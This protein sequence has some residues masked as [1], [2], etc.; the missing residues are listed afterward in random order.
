MEMYTD[1]QIKNL[2][3][4]YSIYL[5]AYKNSYE[6]SIKLLQL[7]NQSEIANKSIQELKDI[8]LE[9]QLEHRYGDYTIDAMISN[10]LITYTAKKNGTA[11][12]GLKG[13]ILQN[14]SDIPIL[15]KYSYGI[16]SNEINTTYN[17]LQGKNKCICESICCDI[18]SSLI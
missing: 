1:A 14:V 7:Q 4:K 8:F 3:A 13:T 11:I 15:I 16:I 10:G 2:E 9:Y 6:K 5:D 17:N 12:K 18:M